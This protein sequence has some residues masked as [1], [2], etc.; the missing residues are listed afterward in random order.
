MTDK[1]V[2]LGG[3]PLTEAEAAE[4][5]AGHVKFP[6][7]STAGRYPPKQV[8][9]P[10]EPASDPVE[11]PQTHKEANL[12]MLDDVRRLV[13]A[14]QLE[15]LV[16]VARQR[17][18]GAFLTDHSLTGP[19]IPPNELF[20]YAGVMSALVNEITDVASTLAP[21]LLSDGTVIQPAGD[22]YE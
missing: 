11:E 12:R 8:K 3:K 14:D 19:S 15:G 16:I 10:G 9:L 1:I 7:P 13:E 20:A 22:D 6:P 5:A 2:T 21:C 18:R 4:R 17:G